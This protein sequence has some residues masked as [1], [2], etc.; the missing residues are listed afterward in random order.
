MVIDL[1]ER[2]GLFV[3]YVLESPPGDI[4]NNHMVLAAALRAIPP[5]PQIPMI[6]IL[7]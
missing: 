3:P 4:Q 7:S 6:P 5:Q 1:Q 2:F